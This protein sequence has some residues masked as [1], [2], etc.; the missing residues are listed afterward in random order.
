MSSSKKCLECKDKEV[1]SGWDFCGDDCANK[2]VNDRFYSVSGVTHEH[3]ASTGES[4]AVSEKG[5]KCK[6]CD[7]LVI[8]KADGE[9]GGEINEAELKKLIQHTKTCS[10]KKKEAKKEEKKPE[11]KKKEKVKKCSQCQ[12]E[13]SLPIIVNYHTNYGGGFE[14][15]QI[16]HCLACWGKVEKDLRHLMMGIYETTKDKMDGQIGWDE[17]KNAWVTKWDGKERIIWQDKSKQEEN[18]KNQERGNKPTNNEKKNEPEKCSRCQVNKFTAKDV[19]LINKSTRE[20][21]TIYQGLI[22]KPCVEELLKCQKCNT[23]TAVMI[24]KVDEQDIIICRECYNEIQQKILEEQQRLE[25]EKQE[26]ERKAEQEKAKKVVESKPKE[27]PKPLT[28]QP[29]NNL[30]SQQ[31]ENN[32]NDKYSQE[33]LQKYGQ[34]YQE[35]KGSQKLGR[36]KTCDNWEERRKKNYYRKKV[37]RYCPRHFDYDNSL[38][39]LAAKSK[40]EKELLDHENSCPQ[41][42]NQTEQKKLKQTKWEETKKSK[43]RLVYA[44]RKCWGKITVDKSISDWEKAKKQAWADLVYHEKQECGNS[45]LNPKIAIYFSPNQGGNEHAHLS[46]AEEINEKELIMEQDNEGEVYQEQVIQPTNKNYWPYIFGGIGIIS[47]VG[48]IV[49]LVNKKNKKIGIIY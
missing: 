20:T 15:K 31:N 17:G 39:F 44:C 40:V 13:L 18:K 37:C 22:C 48:V 21:K 8:K 49:W 30:P 33:T 47:L 27:N 14:D 45:L 42:N 10:G 24:S 25:L 41:K 6:K 3:D 7:E 38:E 32:E 46:Y 11:V 2:F 16:F 35:L 29:S 1:A 19:V 28:S 23:R 9:V 36:V 34:D 12:K 43:E 4:R 26:Q 5:S